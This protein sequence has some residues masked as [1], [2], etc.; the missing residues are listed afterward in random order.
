MQDRVPAPGKENRVRIRLDDGQTIEGVFEYADEASVQGSAYNKANVLPD[1]V[2]A[3][4]GV[5]TSAEPKDAYS[6]VVDLIATLKSDVTK[7][8]VFGTYT[9]NSGDSQEINLG[10]EPLIVFVRKADQFLEDVTSGS[11]GLYPYFEYAISQQ[12]RD[13]DSSSLEITKSGFIVYYGNQR[14]S[15]LLNYHNGKYCY[16]A[17]KGTV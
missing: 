16:I 5:P 4:L 6:R 14:Y 15:P 2:C 17:I 7:R 9:G 10:F 8:I 11:S 12:L 1:D 13:E 3:A